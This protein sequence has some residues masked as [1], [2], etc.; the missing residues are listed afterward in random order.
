[1]L[2]VLR[3]MAHAYRTSQDTPPAPRPTTTRRAYQ[4]PR[5]RIHTMARRL[6]QEQQQCAGS[7]QPR[8]CFPR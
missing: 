1:M 7:R 2:R 5:H 3:R 6:P 8:P 4:P